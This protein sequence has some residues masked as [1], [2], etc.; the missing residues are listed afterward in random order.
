MSSSMDGGRT[1]S[2]SESFPEQRDLLWLELAREDLPLDRGVRGE[3]RSSIVE[4]P[5]FDHRE[6]HGGVLARSR[7]K[8]L[9]F[10]EKA[11]QVLKVAPDDALFLRRRVR[12]EG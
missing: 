1:C 7:Q 10:G 4:A 9:P 3:D 5:A 11:F 12:M 2:S 8:Q 6:P